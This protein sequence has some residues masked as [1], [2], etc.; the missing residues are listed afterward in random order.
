MAATTSISIA[1]LL[2]GLP[3]PGLARRI[4]PRRI[5]PGERTARQVLV[6]DSA[7]L[8]VLVV[9][10]H[11]AMV[12]QGGQGAFPLWATAIS[13]AAA[14]ATLL[15]G[16]L[17]RRVSD[18]TLRVLATVAVAGYYATLVSFPFAVP[19]EGIARIPWTLSASGAA[20]AA[21]LV[22][23]GRGLAWLTV[24]AGATAGILYRTLYG[25]LDL[26]GVVNDAQALLTGAVICVIGAHILSVGRG[27][28][29]AAA[30]TT[31]AAARESAERGRLTART[32]AAALVH[33]EVLATLSLAASGLPIPRER[34]AEQAREAASMV[35]RLA[36]EQAHEPASLRTALAEEA[37]MHGAA[38]LV[39]DE[40]A[41]AAG[42]TATGPT[43]V[44]PSASAAAGA[45]PA[46]TIAAPSEAAHEALIGA[47]RQALRNSELHAPGA[48][49]RVVLVQA[50]AE[51]RV[52]ISDDGPGF[53]PAAIADDRL[54]IRQSIV[55]RLARLSGGSAEIES[56][57]GRGTLVR[58]R[59]AAAPAKGL[60]AT[61]GAGARRALRAGV[62][63]LA[64]LY[65]VVQV[66][67]AVLAAVAVPHSWPL[68]LGML[69]LAL[70]AA[71]VL[72]RSPRRVPSPGRTAVVLALSCGGLVVAAAAA[73]IHHGALY[74]YGNAWFAVAVAFLLVALA[75]RRRIVA[76]LAGAGVIVAVL[77]VTGALLGMPAGAIV[78]VTV[79]PVVIV[80]LAVALLVAVERMQRRIAELHQDAVASAERE[81]WTLAARA[82]LTARVAE[83]ARTA[84]PLLERIGEGGEPTQAQRREYA[85]CEGEL[86][87]AL[88]AGSLAREPVIGVVAAARERGVDV[89]LLDDSGGAVD[90]G[91]VDPVVSWM[92]AEIATARIRAVGRL[93]PPG[94]EARASVSVD[95]RLTEF[96]AN[97]P[98]GAVEQGSGRGARSVR[99]R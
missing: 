38:F 76:A 74:S 66:L 33:D 20:A 39:C 46:P 26:D 88:R 60:D 98:P 15:A 99:V 91:L 65:V 70:V 73:G 58:L 32:R 96:A 84:V 69:A 28:D 77:V 40:R 11:L 49:R 64:L 94:R 8:I 35:S 53:D 25:G 14:G 67:C 45:G 30:S 22:A 72:R 56:A 42:P 90:D 1:P 10:V 83:L 21:A 36:D 3:E 47:T 17:A 43:A 7:L 92:A 81:S 27:L 54:G 24:A 37:R 52:E 95:G 79:R 50:E 29:A 82:E 18:H 34:L 12:A 13:W 23:G 87:D 6:I 55:G 4:W 61:G 19:V 5:G 93:L 9:L 62:G 78:Q 16:I 63:V 85:S 97:R 31:A 80:G 44:G 51:L 2:S 57:P 86:R 89:V 59:C 41:M 68:Q 48:A 75:L 71:D